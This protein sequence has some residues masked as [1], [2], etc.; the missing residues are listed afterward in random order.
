MGTIDAIVVQDVIFQ[1][2]RISTMSAR[3]PRYMLPD[4]MSDDRYS[5]SLSIECS[6]TN[7]RSKIVSRAGLVPLGW[8]TS[9]SKDPYRTEIEHLQDIWLE[10][11]QFITDKAGKI[12]EL[13]FP[14]PHHISEALLGPFDYVTAT[15]TSDNWKNILRLGM[16]SR[17]TKESQILTSHCREA[18]ENSEPRDF[19]FGD[20]YLPYC[21]LELKTAISDLL[22]ETMNQSDWNRKLKESMTKMSVAMI[23][24]PRIYE[25]EFIVAIP[26]AME[27]FENDLE[28]FEKRRIFKKHLFERKQHSLEP[29]SYW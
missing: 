7:Y 5:M 13:P 15:I 29:V 4:L 8:E 9:G 16:P 2:R 18:L 26:K 25:L 19:L 14:V 27:V 1:G 24:N 23:A 22:D 11:C 6:D 3:F 12:G 20:Y 21:T 28:N 10:C 17:F